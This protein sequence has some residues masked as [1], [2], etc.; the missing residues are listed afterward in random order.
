M[1]KILKL[2]ETWS[3][4]INSWTWTKLYGKRNEKR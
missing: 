1:N 2:I 3:G 4:K